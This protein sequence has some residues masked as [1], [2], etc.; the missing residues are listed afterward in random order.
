MPDR[1]TDGVRYDRLYYYFS[2]FSG[3]SFD[4]D[5]VSFDFIPN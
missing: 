4:F 1:L 2:F 5:I 3:D